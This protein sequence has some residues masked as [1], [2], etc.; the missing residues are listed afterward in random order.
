MEW[1]APLA[2]L[3]ASSRYY[4]RHPKRHTLRR[5]CLHITF[6]GFARSAPAVGVLAIL[7]TVV[8]SPTRGA[9][10][11]LISAEEIRRIS[12]NA[13]DEFVMAI[14]NA[15]GDFRAAGLNT[16]LRMAHFLTQVMTETGGL[17][18]IDENMNY[19]F[20]TLMRV[21]S[22]RVVSES[23]AHEIAGNPQK[24]ANWVYRDRNGNGDW[25]S[26]D[27]WKYR[28]SGY[29]QL[30][31]RGNFRGRGRELDL[32]LEQNPEMA[33][34]VPEGLVA[35]IAYWKARNINSA[36]DDNDILRVR[37]L[38]NGPAAHGLPQSKIWFNRAWGR[39]F[40][41]KAGTGPASSEELAS[42]GSFNEEA[43]FDDILEDAGVLSQD[44]EAASDPKMTHTQAIK[45]FQNEFGL[46]ETGILDEATQ[47]ELL[48]PREWR[49]VDDASFAPAS[50]D[51]D[52]E[53][54]VSFQLGSNGAE[55]AAVFETKSSVGTGKTV[56]DPNMSVADVNAINEAH[57]T[58][59][60]YERGN[61]PSELFVPFS[62]VGDDTRVA[63][64]DTTGFPARAIV[65][66]IFDT[67]DGS[68][69][70]CTGAMISKDTV[71]TAG[72]C[73]HSGTV[74]GM[75]YKNFQVTPGR[76]LGAA[77]FGSCLGKEAFVLSGWTTAPT[78][79]ESSDYDL[80]A[81]KLNCSLGDVTGWVG[82]RVLADG[83]VGL[84]TTV[85]GYAADRPP[86]GRQWVSEDQLRFLWAYKG[87]YQNDTFGGTSGAPVF[88][89]GTNNLIIGVHTNGVCG[90]E[91]GC[92]NWGEPWTSNNAF[93]RL[94][95]E[96]LARI[97]E[98]IGR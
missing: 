97:Q 42:S 41:A 16:R 2:W 76:N 55:E 64:I 51:V 47:E 20:A 59:A 37:V 23:K 82:V 96:R 3:C 83:E 89:T 71:L 84:K 48:D 78:P 50:P 11:L 28:G 90:P 87:F 12:P 52:R 73:V 15:E 62:V 61:A 53:Q 34:R 57:G 7:S 31:G 91:T 6:A 56:S 44:F 25:L 86:P 69:G 18:R 9:E 60:Q 66:I 30:T 21:F 22:R 85:E 88:A 70:F 40:K 46:P 49:H 77:P 75:P 5:G 35:A 8:S 72:H 79:K 32:P 58:Y 65:Q 92:Q 39:V 29:I 93:T 81:I 54:T 67:S 13:N 14:V 95:Q 45:K 10:P 4:L 98:W 74:S 33:R 17:S 94:T 43:A 26:G 24:V 80:G 63:V 27:G 19:S 38:V 36:A 68:R 1:P